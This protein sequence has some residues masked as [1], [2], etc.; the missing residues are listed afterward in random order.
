MQ[1]LQATCGRA[2]AMAPIGDNEYAV[3]LTGTNQC[4]E[5]IPRLEQILSRAAAGH[6]NG[7]GV[8]LQCRIGVAR[9]P[10][11]GYDLKDLIARA[12]AAARDLAGSTLSFQFIAERHRAHG[13]TH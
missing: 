13:K 1:Q 3:L 12:S 9:T 11:D 2:S 10:M 8:Q 7:D 5:L 6:L 4:S